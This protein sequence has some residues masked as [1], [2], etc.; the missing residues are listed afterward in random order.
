MNEMYF[1]WTYF[2]IIDVK[3][4]MAIIYYD[5]NFISYK[6]KETLICFFKVNFKRTHPTHLPIF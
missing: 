4:L 5:R 3:Y 1:W 2:I 6:N